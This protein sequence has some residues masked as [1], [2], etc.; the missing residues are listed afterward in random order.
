MGNHSNVSEYYDLEGEIYEADAANAEYQAPQ[1]FVTEIKPFIKNADTVLDIGIGTGLSSLVLVSE[2]KQ[3][4]GL[5]LSKKLLIYAKRRKPA[6]LI[7]G[8]LTKPLPFRNSSFDLVASCATLNYYNDIGKPLQEM[9]R[10]T[11]ADGIIAFTTSKT[12]LHLQTPKRSIRF[13]SHNSSYL[14]EH[15]D[16]A[17]LILYTDIL[18]HLL[19]GKQI[20]YSV[21]VFKKWNGKN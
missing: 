21:Y 6:N 14:E 19:E 1:N 2:G 4:C 17:D 20:Y 11:K 3:V 12:G 5:D 8:D 13:F 10:I 16:E 9:Q 15:L 7:L 18:A